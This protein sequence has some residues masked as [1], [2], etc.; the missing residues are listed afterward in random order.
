MLMENVNYQLLMVKS[1]TPQAFDTAKL[2]LKYV[3]YVMI[4][5]IFVPVM[6]IIV[7]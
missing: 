5:V 6:V 2:M 4:F 7:W 1:S 3:V